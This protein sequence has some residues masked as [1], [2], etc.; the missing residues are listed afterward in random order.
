MKVF[1][2][3]DKGRV[4]SVNQD[5]FYEPRPGETFAVIADG[6]GGHQAGDVASVMAVEEF[7][8]WLKCAPRLSEE[9]MRYA[10]SEANRTV[11]L[12]S[13]AD[14][15]KAGMGT[16]LTALWMDDDSVLLA[17]IGDSRAYR[18]RDGELRQMSQ[19]HSLVSELVES[20]QLTEEEARV[21]P[22]RNIITRALGTASRVE[23]DI[24][25]CNRKKG[26]VWLLCT[27][28]LTNYM[29]RE[30]LQSVL[31]SRRKWQNKAEELVKKALGRGGS[32]N[33]TVLIIVCDGGAS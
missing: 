25:R 7:T 24:S 13:R 11:Y 28:G 2:L 26:D 17:H 15:D 27:D 18:L 32:D 5:A 29:S 21:H 12:K 10:V 30:E 16:T 3:T 33:V 1:A 9:T 14:K 23:P 6:M 4:R 19:D 20:G 8:R 22:K 31:K